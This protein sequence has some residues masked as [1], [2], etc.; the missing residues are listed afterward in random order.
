MGLGYIL[1]Q[2]SL[3]RPPQITY[4]CPIFLKPLLGFHYLWPNTFLI[5][6]V[7]TTTITVHVEYFWD[8]LKTQ[9]DL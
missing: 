8:V 9:S 2:Q 4:V 1:E 3:T 5:Y 7:R 6:K